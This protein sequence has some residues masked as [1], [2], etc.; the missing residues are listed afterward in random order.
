MGATQETEE[1]LDFFAKV[2]SRAQ[3]MS[4]REPCL[5]LWSVAGEDCKVEARL[6]IP[7]MEQELRT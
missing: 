7:E 4:R 3:I 5:R 1:A 2:G 6:S